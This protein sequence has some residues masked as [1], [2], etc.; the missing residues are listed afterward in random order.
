MLKGALATSIGSDNEYY[1][2]DDSEVTTIGDKVGLQQPSPES[3]YF[4]PGLHVDDNYYFGHSSHDELDK[5]KRE[6]RVE[7]GSFYCHIP[8]MDFMY[9][10][11]FNF[12][13][14]EFGFSAGEVSLTVSVRLDGWR[15]QSQKRRMSC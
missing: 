10:T 6:P 15:E 1:P 7:H 11:V 13:F 14:D 5:V 2:F 8:Q 9:V 3:G 4:K 12:G